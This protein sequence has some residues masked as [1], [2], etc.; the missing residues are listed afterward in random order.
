M[1]SSVERGSS[2]RRHHNASLQPMP[3]SL[4]HLIRNTK[5]GLYPYAG[6][7][8]FSTPFGRDGIITAMQ[9]LWLDPDIAR[10][11]LAYL[12]DAQADDTVPERDSNP[13][14]ILHETRLGEMAA[15]REIPFGKY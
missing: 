4:R 11:V 2:S 1:G 15:L 3:T 6:V 10:G 7:P 8:W 5:Q 14:K 13:G 12:A 9:T